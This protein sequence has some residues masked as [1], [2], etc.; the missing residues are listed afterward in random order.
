M[1]ANR[2]WTRRAYW[3]CQIFGWGLW[4][5]MGLWMVRAQGGSLDR[6]NVVGYALFGLYSVA[7][8]HALGRMIERRGWLAKSAAQAAVRLLGAV[9]AVSSIQT[10][11]VVSVSVALAGSLKELAQVGPIL[12]L[13]INI[14]FATAVWTALFTTISSWLRSRRQREQAATLE[15]EMN[16]A[17]LKTLEAQISPHFLFNCLNSIRGMIAEN[18]PQAQ[19]MVTRLANLLRH[20]LRLDVQSTEPL[21]EQVDV[22]ADYLSLESVRFDERL[23]THLDIEPGSRAC[24][25]PSMLLQTLVENAIKHGIALL[26][27]GGEIVVRSRLDSGTLTLCVE[28]SGR[29]APASSQSTHVGLANLRERL[30]IIHGDGARLELWEVPPDRVR[31][32]VAIP[33]GAV[34]SREDN[35]PGPHA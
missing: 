2:T 32:T 3:T 29:L 16:A 34:P 24:T 21:G 6:N 5:A 10:V 30:R 14:A 33:S 13:W 7:L 20:N 8:T 23:R 19:D 26:P 18:P 4:C 15:R 28:N 25:V 12:V 31:A 35:G 9:L 11:L 22:V 17:R 1:H 27:E